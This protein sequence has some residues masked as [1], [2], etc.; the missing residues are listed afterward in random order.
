MFKKSGEIN[1]QKVEK[2]KKK[3]CLC[4]IVFFDLPPSPLKFRR[5]GEEVELFPWDFGNGTF[6]TLELEVYLVHTYTSVG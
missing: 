4:F 5:R 3:F 1:A 2:M 6:S